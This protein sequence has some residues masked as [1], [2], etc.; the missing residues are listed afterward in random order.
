[1]DELLFVSDFGLDKIVHAKLIKSYIK[2][3]LLYQYKY[4]FKGLRDTQQTW[5]R[6][7]RCCL[8]SQTERRRTN[9]CAQRSRAQ[10]NG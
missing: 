2:L 4:E 8:Q 5:L 10:I 6:I 7:F 1:M 9:L 3:S